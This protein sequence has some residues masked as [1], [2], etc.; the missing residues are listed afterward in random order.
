MRHA[1]LHIV[2]KKGVVPFDGALVMRQ[3]LAIALLLVVRIAKQSVKLG[4]FRFD[5]NSFLG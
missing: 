3:R 2:V 1:P 4:F 5:A